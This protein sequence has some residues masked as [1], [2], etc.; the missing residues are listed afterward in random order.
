MLINIYVT[1]REDN[2]NG[3]QVIERTRFFDRQ[4]DRE[5]LG[6]KTI[7]LITLKGEDIIISTKYTKDCLLKQR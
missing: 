7:C 1:F 3:F 2:L 6:G 4:T 5:M